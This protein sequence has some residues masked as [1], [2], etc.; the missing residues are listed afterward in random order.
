MGA[1]YGGYS[2]LMLSILYPD[3]Y[4]CAV[5]AAGV[6]DLPLMFSSGDTKNFE[7]GLSAWKK[8]IGDPDE[9]FE[10]LVNKS[11]VY[12]AEKITKPV[13]L[14]HGVDDERVTIEHSYRLKKILDLLGK[15]SKF[16]TLNDEG[17][18]FSHINS[19]IFYIAESVEF[20]QKVLGQIK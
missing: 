13:F 3:T 7:S 10:K 20:I 18:S 9:D 15:E 2:S 12:L 11:P 4:Q 5:S 6:T 8:I 14:V 1:S 17:H 19:E 16:I